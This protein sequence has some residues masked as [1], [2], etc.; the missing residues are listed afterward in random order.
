MKKLVAFD[1]DGTLATSKQAIDAEMAQQL[2]ELLEIL[3]VCVIS[4]GDWPQFERQ[5][6]GPLPAGSAFNQLFLM[7]T[8]G[9]KLYRFKGGWTQCYAELFNADERRRVIEAL[10]SAIATTLVAED[11]AWGDR[12]EDRGSQI[13]FSGLGQQA[14]PDAK[15]QW[16][17]DIRKRTKLKAVL[18]ELLPDY[19]VRIGGTTSVDITRPGIDKAYAIR[20]LQSLSGFDISEMLFIGDALYPGGNDAPVRDAGV[21]TIAVRDIIET[22][23]VMDT[24][25][26]FFN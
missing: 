8:S 5:L 13:T 21:A 16:D 15:A 24:I 2:V 20:K 1:L 7:P 4:G 12:I 9:T 23:L 26:K 25:L 14:P 22:K 10:T 18:D 11:L 19:A 6:L 17:P 3:P